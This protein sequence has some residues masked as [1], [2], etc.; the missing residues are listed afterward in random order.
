MLRPT[1]NKTIVVAID[2]SRWDN[3]INEYANLS[4]FNQIDLLELHIKKIYES[5]RKTDPDSK[6]VIA[7]REY[8]ITG[9]GMDLE[10]R[11]ISTKAKDYLKEKMS[12]L[13]QELPNLTIV[14]GTVAV[15]KAV[16]F[17]KLKTVHGYYK[18]HEW[19]EQIENSNPKNRD[20]HLTSWHKNAIDKVLNERL[21]EADPEANV[22]RNVCYIFNGK[23]I[24]RHDK[25]AP[26]DETTKHEFFQ[27]AKGRNFQSIF[28]IDG[29]LIGVEICREH[30]LG[31]LQKEAFESK[32][33]KPLLHFIVS[34]SIKTDLD[35]LHGAYAVHLDSMDH[36]KLILLQGHAEAN[37]EVEL[38]N[39]NILDPKAESELV[40]VQPVYPFMFKLL[41]YIEAKENE[42]RKN[43]NLLSQL[44][45]LKDAIKKNCTNDVYLDSDQYQNLQRYFQEK[46]ATLAAEKKGI[47]FKIN[48][49]L[50]K[51]LT[52]DMEKIIISLAEILEKEKQ[53]A[54]S[55]NLYVENNPEEFD[56]Q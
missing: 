16:N 20:K 8:G 23:K 37:V 43:K 10:N 9:Q 11:P 13:C 29:D 5:I 47:K 45:V 3:Q 38:Y 44:G 56:H 54:K 27:P 21:E 36:P 42:F 1:P 7:W 49:F 48:T 2:L 18:N 34:D 33:K 26:M 46:L 12:A 39:Y 25:K 35:K 31:A 24:L 40:L 22:I 32:S 14:S 50:Q 15:R 28:E 53:N 52:V 41:D 30:A 55:M 6:I 19:I 17:E 51:D 4:T